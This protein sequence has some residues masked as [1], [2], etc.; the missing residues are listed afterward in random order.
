MSKC[1]HRCNVTIDTG[2]VSII[3]G[4]HYPALLVHCATL[5]SREQR[6][7]HGTIYWRARSS[8]G[9]PIS[10]TARACA[11]PARRF[12]AAGIPFLHFERWTCVSS[13][14]ALQTYQRIDATKL[15]IFRATPVPHCTASRLKASM[16]FWAQTKPPRLTRRPITC[17]LCMYP[18]C[19]QLCCKLQSLSLCDR[20]GEHN[21]AGALGRRAWA[22][23]AQR[24]AQQATQSNGPCMG[25]RWA[26]GLSGCPMGAPALLLALF[27]RIAAK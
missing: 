20:V 22:S 23:L 27:E 13:Q 14:L 15:P 26:L 7:F 24:L 3:E 4:S 21:M 17:T 5:S 2:S 18:K 8:A 10:T 12:P 6:A 1:Q 25:N 9:T 16:R 11:I 19:W